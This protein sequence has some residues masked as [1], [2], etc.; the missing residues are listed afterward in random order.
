V[1]F[2]GAIGSTSALH[3]EGTGIET[4]WNHFSYCFPLFPSLSLIFAYRTGFSYAD[5]P[6]DY[7]Y[8]EDVIAQDLYV[9]MQNFFLLFP[10]YSKL[11]FYITGES[12]RGV[13]CFDTSVLV[14]LGTNHHLFVIT[15]MPATMVRTSRSVVSQK[16]IGP[17]NQ[18]HP[19]TVPAFA[20]RTL[21][22]N[23]KKDGPFYINLNGIG[24]GNG[25]VDPYI[26]Y[27]AYPEFAYAPTSKLQRSI[28]H[29]SPLFCV[30]DTST[31]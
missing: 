15:S 27:A 3:A 18:P 4:Q 13:L 19:T 28:S 23:Q 9:F 17:H 14:A 8:D 22:G 30:T 11:P 5:N 10:Q 24:I 1:R 25:W 2:Y 31:S 6:L 16:R 26:Q 12:V 20:Y 29:Q 21:V 7:E